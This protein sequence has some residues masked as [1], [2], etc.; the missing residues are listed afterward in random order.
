MRIANPDLSQI[1]ETLRERLPGDFLTFLT[2]AGL[3]DEEDSKL[4]RFWPPNEWS[5]VDSLLVFAD[6][7]IHSHA[8][9]LWLSGVHAGKVS[10]L[11]GVDTDP[12]PPIGSFAEFLDAY[13]TDDAVLCA[14]NRGD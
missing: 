10:L 13:L 1:P 5:E 6:F 12:Q 11:F 3:P 7:L 14:F 4:I 9:A 2:V 8:Y